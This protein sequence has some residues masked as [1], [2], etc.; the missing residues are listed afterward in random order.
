MALTEVFETGD[1][2]WEKGVTA[3]YKDETMGKQALCARG[4]T[5]RRGR[6]VA[7]RLGWFCIGR[8]DRLAERERIGD[9]VDARRNLVVLFFLSFLLTFLMFP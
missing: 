5:E 1:M 4:W 8:H 2:N 7:A 9:R 6:G 3:K